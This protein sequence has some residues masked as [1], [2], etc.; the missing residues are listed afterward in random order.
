M[1]A[2]ASPMQVH[3]QSCCHN[4]SRAIPPILPH[5]HIAPSRC[6]PKPS[7]SHPI[8]PSGQSHAAC[9]LGCITHQCN[10]RQCPP[11]PSK[12]MWPHQ[13]GVASQ[14]K[15]TSAQLGMTGAYLKGHMGPKN[16]QS[17]VACDHQPNASHK[18]Q[19]SF[20]TS[21][22]ILPPRTSSPPSYVAAPE[23]GRRSTEV[24]LS[25]A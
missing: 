3:A 21:H 18:L 22:I 24:H 25:T 9:P 10:S 4:K 20:Y 2:H 12:A 8:P 16:A 5:H 19:V 1:Q 17:H 14:Q 15:C 7:P 13:T 11:P 6:M 23:G